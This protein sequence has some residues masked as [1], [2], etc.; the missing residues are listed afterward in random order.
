MFLLLTL[1]TIFGENFQAFQL[2]AFPMV[3]KVVLA[4]I[5]QETGKHRVKMLK[6]EVMVIQAD[7]SDLQNQKLRGCQKTKNENSDFSV[8]FSVLTQ[9][10]T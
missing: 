4:L 2:K 3:L 5:N 10:T 6:L 1:D 9:M 7:W 8:F